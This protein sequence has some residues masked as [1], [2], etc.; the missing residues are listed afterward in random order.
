MS[1][2]CRNAEHAVGPENRCNAS[3]LVACFGEEEGCFT[4]SKACF[5]LCNSR[6]TACLH[7]VFTA[8]ETATERLAGTAGNVQ[9]TRSTAFWISR[10]GVVWYGLREARARR[11]H[12]S[13]LAANGN[14]REAG[15]SR[16]PQL[17]VSG[18]TRNDKTAAP[19]SV[20][21]LEPLRCLLTRLDAAPTKRRLVY[22][23]LDKGGK[24]L[25]VGRHGSG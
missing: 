16:S 5:K 2:S 12:L 14:D 4:S 20:R 17:W 9:A 21:V 22:H 10:C 6:V 25:K 1:S 19:A 11:I 8:A 13:S 18:N 15:T 24:P 3:I 7:D 23:L